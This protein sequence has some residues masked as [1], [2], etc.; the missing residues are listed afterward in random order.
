MES[1]ILSLKKIFFNCKQI[2][3]RSNHTII[4]TIDFLICISGKGNYSINDTGNIWKEQQQKLDLYLALH[5]E[6]ERNEWHDIK[7]KITETPEDK[8]DEL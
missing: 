4:I 5:T 2:T 3:S 8:G 7:N 6:F 1:R